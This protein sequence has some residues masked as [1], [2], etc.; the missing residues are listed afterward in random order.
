MI[1]SLQKICGVIEER[2]CDLLNIKRMTANKV[3]RFLVWTLRLMLTHTWPKNRQPHLY[4]TMLKQAWQKYMSHLMTKP[5]KWFVC[6]VKTHI[7]LGI[8]LVWSESLQC[9]QWVAEDQMF[10]HADSED[11]RR[12]P[13]LIWVSLG[14]KVI[15]LVLSWGNSNLYDSQA[16][17]LCFMY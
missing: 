16:I 11:W 10:L 13:R 1:K 14:A 15:W 3:F 17:K 8:R 9:T 7:S 12:M 5:T 4:S 2:P 6:P